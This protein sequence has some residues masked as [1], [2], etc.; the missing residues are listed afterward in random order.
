MSQSFGSTDDTRHI[1]AGIGGE[2]TTTT[3]EHDEDFTLEKTRTPRPS[4]HHADR[5]NSQA[6]TNSAMEAGALSLSLAL[7]GE[8]KDLTASLPTKI[9]RAH[10]ATNRGTSNDEG[11]HGRHEPRSAVNIPSPPPEAS[12]SGG[13]ESNLVIRDAAISTHSK[14]GHSEPNRMMITATQILHE[15]S[16]GRIGLQGVPS[17][18]GDE[19]QDL[20]D[21]VSF[22]SLE[23]DASFEVKCTADASLQPH[24]DLSLDEIC[25]DIV[26]TAHQFSSTLRSWTSKG[27]R[28]L[29]ELK[30]KQEQ[31]PERGVCADRTIDN[32]E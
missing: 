2:H 13:E 18:H 16:L 27:L 3:V 14:S 32:S 19:H 15:Q 8:A 11:V 29:Q 9:G 20:E 31:D 30:S 26:A 23:F 21:D 17:L 28:T 7:L 5:N 4:N 25:Q 22:S 1:R 6:S 10:S 12:R 24:H